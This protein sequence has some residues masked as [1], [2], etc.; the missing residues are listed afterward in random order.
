LLEGDD[1][2][3]DIQFRQSLATLIELG[4]AD[5]F[6]THIAADWVTSLHRYAWNADELAEHV[7]LVATFASQ[8][9]E[10]HPHALIRVP[11]QYPVAGINSRM[12]AYVC[13]MFTIAP[14]GRSED[15]EVTT[16]DHPRM[17]NRPVIDAIRQFLYAPAMSN[18]RPVAREGYR[19][20]FQFRLAE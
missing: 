11:P 17:F 1:E 5:H 6:T 10:G 4:Y 7:N 18:G 9:R 13:A 3:A 8:R 2:N 16:T 15:I 12:D 14:S 20:C 19:Y